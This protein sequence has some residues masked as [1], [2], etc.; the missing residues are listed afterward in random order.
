MHS[1]YRFI[2]LSSNFGNLVASDKVDI[3]VWKNL[4]EKSRNVSFVY[5][6]LLYKCYCKK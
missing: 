6:I 1:T 4:I 2:S 5:N 3:S